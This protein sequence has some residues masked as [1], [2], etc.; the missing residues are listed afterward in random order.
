MEKKFNYVSI[1]ISLL[2]DYDSGIQGFPE[3]KK[4]RFVY[5][6]LFPPFPFADC[7]QWAKVTML[8][9]TAFS[10]ARSQCCLVGKSLRNL[11]FSVVCCAMLRSQWW[12]QGQE[13]A[14][15]VELFMDIP[16]YNKPM[17]EW[18]CPFH[19]LCAKD[20]E[21]VSGGGM[22]SCLCPLGNQ[23]WEGML[24][25]SKDPSSLAWRSFIGY[26]VQPPHFI[27]EEQRPTSHR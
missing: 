22:D 16:L 19:S 12:E 13:R 14:Y 4:I 8:R 24:T 1:L 17:H 18:N 10:P 9:C 7:L 3:E 21:R 6:S 15:S 26:L 11:P 23:C 2:S 27:D 5:R 20:T 25:D